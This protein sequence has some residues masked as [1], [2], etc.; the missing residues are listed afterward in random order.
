MKDWGC[1]WATPCQG[2]TFPFILTNIAAVSVDLL[3]NETLQEVA[4][5]Q[6]EQLQMFYAV[7]GM[8]F[9]SSTIVGF[10]C[11]ASCPP[12]HTPKC[13]PPRPLHWPRSVSMACGTHGVKGKLVQLSGLASPTHRVSQTCFTASLQYPS[14]GASVSPGEPL[15]LHWQIIFY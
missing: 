13:F 1:C 10:Q 7:Q 8:G 15:G 9:G 2:E 11:L 14:T 12:V 4:Y 3:G 6:A 5:I